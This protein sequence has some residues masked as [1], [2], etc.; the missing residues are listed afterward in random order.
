L[1]VFRAEVLREP[2]RSVLSRKIVSLGPH[3]PVSWR[4]QIPAVTAVL[5]D[6]GGDLSEGKP[7]GEGRESAA[8]RSRYKNKYSRR[9]QPPRASRT[10]RANQK[11]VK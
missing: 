2:R 9:K 6:Y 7:R 8:T 1:V 4:R 5:S 3:G 11:S 10:R